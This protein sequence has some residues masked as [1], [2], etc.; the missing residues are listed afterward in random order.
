VFAE[1]RLRRLNTVFVLVLSILTSLL[2]HFTSHGAYST[3]NLIADWAGSSLNGNV[4]PW[5]DGVNGTSLTQNNTTYTSSNGGYLNFNGTSSYVKANASNDLQSFTTTTMSMF[6][7]IKPTSN[8]G[9]I[10]TLGRDINPNDAD[11]EMWLMLDSNGKL[12]FW[13]YNGGEGVP[14]GLSTSSVTLNSW[15]YVGFTKAI[16]GSNSNITFYI[17][18][19]ASGTAS[20]PSKS[21]S[22]NSFG[23][24][25][26][27]RDNSRFYTGA[28][29]RATVWSSVLTASEV[30]DNYQATNG[31][32]IAPSIT[33]SNATQSVYAG[34]AIS[35]VL[36]TNTG[37]A[38]SYYSI[39]PALP[40]GLSLNT[41]SGTISGAPVNVQSQSSYTL[42]ATNPAGTS[43]ATFNL[44]V[45][46][47]STTM[48]LAAIT[49]ATYRST[50][51]LVVTI[52]GGSGKAT[53]M[54]N[55]KRIAGCIKVPTVASSTITATCNWKP[56]LMNYV[57]I[58]VSYLSSNATYSSAS[59]ASIKV[60]VNKRSGLR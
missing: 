45:L 24:G 31:I 28:I 40:S 25:K 60:W 15:N 16:S 27:V 52:S 39:S 43:S 26:D 29:A 42:T 54:Q 33:I 5:V 51:P 41:S 21:V 35:N 14:S 49:S 19:S 48:T 2:P 32:A 53:F 17:N 30:A 50:T 37:G 9:V 12:L 6:F 18:G 55:G 38:A 36:A 22:L 8:G 10:A 58:S 20:G 57:S 13:D 11:S 7:W 23:L 1:G 59:I 4:D 44:T 46:I 56:S 3:G 34:G 47:N